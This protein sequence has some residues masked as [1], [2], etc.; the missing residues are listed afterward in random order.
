[1]D[2]RRDLELEAVELPVAGDVRQRFA[3]F[4][5]RDQRFVLGGKGIRRGI[6]RRCEQL[7]RVPAEDVLGQEPR[8]EV[9][10]RRDAGDAQPIAGG[11]DVLADRF[12]ETAVASF[13]FSDW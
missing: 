11:G 4:P 8:V 5:P 7:R 3:R 1:V 9:R 2:G 13:S 10:G 6:A 12:Q